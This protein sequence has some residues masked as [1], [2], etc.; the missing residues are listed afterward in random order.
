MYVHCRTNL[1]LA[2]EKWPT[3]MPVVPNVGDHIQSKTKWGVFQLTLK[4]VR[5]TW[6]YSDYY[7]WYPEIELHMTDFQCGLPCSKGKDCTGSIRAFYEWYAPLIGR[8][9]SSFI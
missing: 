8:S 4:V 1:D 3:D 6:K 2:N 5:V 7:D 9:V